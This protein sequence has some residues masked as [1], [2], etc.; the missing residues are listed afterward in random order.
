ML[1]KPLFVAFMVLASTATMGP[2]VAKPPKSDG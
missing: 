2:A 1:K